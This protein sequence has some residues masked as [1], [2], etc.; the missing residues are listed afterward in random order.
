MRLA[1]AE[2]MD[3]F[4][5]PLY[6]LNHFDV[7]SSYFCLESCIS[8]EIDW[9]VAT[10]NA[11]K[12]LKDGGWFL[13]AAMLGSTGYDSPNPSYI[14]SSEHKIFPAYKLTD[15][16]IM[17]RLGE[18]SLEVLGSIVAP[19]ESHGVRPE[20]SRTTYTGMAA[21]VAR[22]SPVLLDELD[23]LDAVQHADA[24]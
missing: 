23:R 11:V 1:K 20:D 7:V 15:E 18:L 8:S 24:A 10:D 17:H 21:Y 14:P 22:K 9:L 19:A 2:E 5:P 13:M 4:Q 16:D 3:I 12:L 6:Y